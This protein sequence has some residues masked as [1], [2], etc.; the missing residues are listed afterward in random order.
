VTTTASRRRSARRPSSAPTVIRVAA[1]CRQSLLR[2]NGGEFGSIQ[3][4][5][6]AIADFVRVQREN[7]WQLL[8]EHYDDENVSGATE[9]REA[10]DRLLDDVEAGKVDKIAV[11]KLD[12]LSRSLAG[13]AKLND[14]LSEHNVAVVSVTQSFDTGTPTG[15]L[16]LNMLMSFAEYERELI[17][18]RV[19]DKVRASKR[20]G[21]WT[22]GVPPLGYDVVDIDAQ[23]FG[24][25]RVHRVLGVNEGRHAAQL[26]R[27][28]D[29]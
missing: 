28:C 19:R 10:L 24:V 4:Q 13:F 8:P 18:E 12:R 23:P 3:A 5:R 17:A 6:Q 25:N 16:H 1:Y 11:Y 27:L 2:E 22:G 14:F 21:R 26:L 9:K 15:R 20:Q 29:H 7:G